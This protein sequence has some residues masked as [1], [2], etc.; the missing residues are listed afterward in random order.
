M[1]LLKDFYGPSNTELAFCRTSGST[2]CGEL[3][4]FTEKGTCIFEIRDYHNSFFV[5][6][7]VAMSKTNYRKFAA[8]LFFDKGASNRYK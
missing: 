5:L 7:G 6:I 8:E 1:N 2:L 3:A 4:V